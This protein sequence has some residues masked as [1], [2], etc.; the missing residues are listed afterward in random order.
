MKSEK[1]DTKRIANGFYTRY[2]DKPETLK[3]I[4]K[5]LQELLEKST[6]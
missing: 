4:I 1:I 3:D 6:I 2:K 5:E